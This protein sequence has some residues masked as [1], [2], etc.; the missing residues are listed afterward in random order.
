M[1][2]AAGTW[3]W[4]VAVAVAAF[5][6][7]R[8]ARA[9]RRGK[10]LTPIS[11]GWGQPLQF[12]PGPALLPEHDALPCEDEAVRWRRQRVTIHAY[13]AARASAPRSA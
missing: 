8:W 7:W 11:D 2:V 1:H 5:G 3:W 13:A 9:P 12:R 10:R 6:T 4:A